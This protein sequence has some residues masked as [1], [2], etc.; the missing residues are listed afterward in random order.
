MK[1][2]CSFLQ[3][4]PTNSKVA[5]VHTN[6][7][8]LII[9]AAVLVCGTAAKFTLIGAQTPYVNNDSL[10]WVQTRQA[11]MRQ[12]SAAVYPYVQAADELAQLGLYDRAVE[13][14][15]EAVS[16]P[17][18]LSREMISDDS[19]PRASRKPVDVT[20]RAGADYIDYN[21]PEI[22]QHDNELI[23]PHALDD[24]NFYGAVSLGARP[25]R[26]PISK[27]DLEVKGSNQYAVLSGRGNALFLD[28]MLFCMARLEGKKNF[29]LEEYEK[30]ITPRG[31]TALRVA[32]TR[33]VGGSKNRSDKMVGEIILDITN[34][35]DTRS[36]TWSLPVGVT[37]EK[38]RESHS[39]YISGINY[40][41]TP[42][43]EWA[44]DDFSKTVSAQMEL[45]YCDYGEIFVDSV[46]KDTASRMTMRPML[47]FSMWS[48]FLSTEVR[49]AYVYE[50]YPQATMP[51]DWGEV[52]VAAKA[53]LKRWK[54]IEPRVAAEYRYEHQG[55]KRRYVKK[56]IIDIQEN[57]N[58][59]TGQIRYDTLWEESSRSLQ[60]TLDGTM[61]LLSGGLLYYPTE[62]IS[63]RVDVEFEESWFP[64][65]DNEIKDFVAEPFRA[66]CPEIGMRIERPGGEFGVYVGYEKNSS[67]MPDISDY[68]RRDGLLVGIH[69][70]LHP[71][72]A[73]SIYGIGDYGLTIYDKRGKPES[74]LS[75]SAG[76]SSSIQ[77]GNRR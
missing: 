77:F 72:P 45:G 2:F 1:S 9:Y 15:R 6:Q 20:F 40:H 57:V 60:Y 30:F 64:R 3:R 31:D 43:F 51:Q 19:S 37:F 74:N 46:P 44:S 56:Y 66:L 11:L 76:I 5:G 69:T 61:L 50:R 58:E 39:P 32:D 8:R 48:D 16:A 70:H 34:R 68:Q 52:S 24:R 13:M 54:E 35:Y 7:K 36:S 73:I 4:Q 17:S 25:S 23:D 14:I 65:S 29:W 67:K 49:S 21:D 26:G 22:E 28:S 41:I 33:F 12:D 62:T 63:F 27:I 55:K 75:L 38:Y 42:R 53:S 47:S 10:S 59:F 71:N 18:D